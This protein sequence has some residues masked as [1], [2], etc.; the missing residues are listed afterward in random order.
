M[1]HYKYS[2]CSTY[3]MKDLLSVGENCANTVHYLFSVSEVVVDLV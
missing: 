3:S 2:V 1:F